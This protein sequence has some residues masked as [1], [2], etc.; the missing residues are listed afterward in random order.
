MDRGSEGHQPHP[1]EIRLFVCEA[2][3]HSGADSIVD[4]PQW[5]RIGGRW[6]VHR[7]RPFPGS[8]L[9]NSLAGDVHKRRRRV[10]VPAFGPVEA[11]GFLPY[12]MDA[13]TRVRE[14][15]LYLLSFRVDTGS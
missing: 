7:D 4:R 14:L 1:P 12:V 10:V 8:G 13:V 9:P 15:Y 3:Q 2:E 6:V 5:Y 11:K